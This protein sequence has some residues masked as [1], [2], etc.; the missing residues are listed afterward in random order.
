[1]LLFRSEEHV[2]RWCR[3]W[4]LPRGGT[5]SPETAWRLARA[6]YSP[7]RRDRAWRRRTVDET[8]ALLAERAAGPARQLWGLVSQDRGIPRPHMA[9]LRG[10]VRVGDLTSGTFSPT[11]KVGIGLALL[12]TAAGLGEGDEVEV[13]VRGRRSRMVVTKP[14]FVQP[15]VR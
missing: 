8:D 5:L 11:R 12:D 14:P 4:S 7:D 10:T 1:M 2:D 3:A 15:S 9:V 13:D 6:W